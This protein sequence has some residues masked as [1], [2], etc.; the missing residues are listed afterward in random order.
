MLRL[1][2]YR[3]MLDVYPDAVISDP[4]Y[5][6]ATHK[7]HNAGRPQIMSATGQ[8]T[9]RSL[10]YSHWTPAD[11][12]EFVEFWS[13]RTKGWMACMTSDDLIPHWR[14]AYRLAGRYTFAPVIIIQK[15][16]RLLGD[17]PASWARY[18]MTARPSTR[19][20]QRWRCL[21]GMYLSKLE[22]G[23][24]IVGAKPVALMQEIVRDYSNAGDLV[25]DPCA[26]WG[27]TLIAAGLEG[28][29]AIG[30]EIDSETHAKFQQRVAV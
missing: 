9:G 28:R 5:G 12:Y 19:E 13:Y 15:V 30:C 7:G 17:G 23:A 26:G 18:L 20:A 24:P 6:A 14:E 1:C 29:Q 10:T 25:C 8:A 4:P 2:D 21:P 11:V 27:S 16:P 22:R 3:S